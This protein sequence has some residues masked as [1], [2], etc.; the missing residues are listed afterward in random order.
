M[1][2]SSHSN[3]HQLND[4]PGWTNWPFLSQSSL[5]RAC[6][7]YFAATNQ[8]KFLIE[9]KSLDK[10]TIGMA[11]TGGGPVHIHSFI[12][13][14]N[15]HDP[16]TVRDLNR[17]RDIDGRDNYR[18]PGL[19][20][21]GQVRGILETLE[22]SWNYEHESVIQIWVHESSPHWPHTTWKDK[23]GEGREKEIYNP[24]KRVI[25]TTA[26]IRIVK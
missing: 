26:T 13:I 25:S 11:A 16:P 3:H 2:R 17:S 9:L 20:W 1:N 18:R 14:Q 5:Y 6:L 8:W 4:P 24:N 21:S 23:K 10:Q 22:K 7:S 12:H 15:Q 19:V